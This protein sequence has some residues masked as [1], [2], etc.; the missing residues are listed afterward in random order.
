MSTVTPRLMLAAWTM[1]ACW[2]ARAM[3]ASCSLSNPVVP[4]TSTASAWAASSACRT[5]T[6]GAVKSITASDWA[7]SATGSA[8]T[9]M[10]SSPRPACAP[11]SWP[12]AGLSG[13]SVPPAM[14]QAPVSP[15]TLSS[16]R[17]M[18]PAQPTI[19]IL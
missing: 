3:A 5:E 15:A 18:R 10:P 4:S 11:R 16:K 9:L 6:A 14:T 12:C 8:P 2:A 19:P 17:P 7:N 1:V 13:A